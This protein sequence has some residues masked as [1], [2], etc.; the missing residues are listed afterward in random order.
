[1]KGEDNIRIQSCKEVNKQE[2]IDKAGYYL[3]FVRI[4]NKRKINYM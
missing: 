4:I 2:K 3:L 1:M